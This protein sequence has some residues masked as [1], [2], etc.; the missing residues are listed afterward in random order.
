M[1]AM[2]TGTVAQV[3]VAGAINGYGVV[4]LGDVETITR[5]GAEVARRRVEGPGRFVAA[6]RDPRLGRGA[7][8]DEAGV[9]VVYDKTDG[10]S[11]A[12]ARP[13]AARTRRRPRG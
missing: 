8:P 2:D 13:A 3:G 4:V 9:V 1:N 5:G 12:R 7:F 6:A 11:G 10:D